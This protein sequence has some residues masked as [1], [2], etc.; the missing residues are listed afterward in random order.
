MRGLPHAG[1]RDVC[2]SLIPPAYRAT[3]VC[4]SRCRADSCV[5]RCNPT[6]RGKEE[7]S[8]RGRGLTD[9][10]NLRSQWSTK[11]NNNVHVLFFA[12]LEPEGCVALYVF[13]FLVSSNVPSSTTLGR[14]TPA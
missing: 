13:I 12:M 3:T 9:L 5:G 14:Y 7:Q 4:S 11:N 8:P 6:L 2:G 10:S 1:C